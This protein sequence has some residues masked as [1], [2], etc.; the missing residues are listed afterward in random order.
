[1]PSRRAAPIPYEELPLGSLREDRIEALWCYRSAIA[2]RQLVLPDGRMDLVARGTLAPSGQ[3]ADIRLA[4]AGPADRP[5]FVSTPAATVT[6]GVRF[7][8]G[9]GGACLGLDADSLRN[10]V[11][12]GRAAEALIGPSAQAMLRA[13]SVDELRQALVD[14]AHAMSLRAAPPAGHARVLQA[15]ELMRHGVAIGALGERIGMAE[16]TLRRDV[17]ASVGLPLRTLGGILRFQRTLARLQ[18]EAVR[19]LGTL[20]AEAGYSDQ[21]HMTRAFRRF[22]N[23]TPALPEPAPVVEHIDHHVPWP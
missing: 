18:G 22:G 2:R 20:A 1:M 9:W 5:G 23:F 21:A 3:L 7:R 8:I 14:T 12:V 11:A 4:L 10:R 6:L 19:S 15:V 13:C 17:D 16:R